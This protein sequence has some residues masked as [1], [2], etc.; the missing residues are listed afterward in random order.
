MEDFVKSRLN[1]QFNNGYYA[2]ILDKDNDS[3]QQKSI[4]NSRIMFRSASK[5]AT[6]EGIDIDCI[7]FD[8]YDRIGGEAE[9]SGKE[10]LA[11]SKYGYIRRWSTPTVPD[12]GIDKLYKESNQMAWLIRCDHCGYEQKM[13]Y[14]KNIELVD[15]S[16][17]DEIGK[18][19]LPG[20]YRFVCQRCNKPLDSSRWYNGHWEEMAPGKNRRHGY[21]ITQL[22]AVN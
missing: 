13:D 21:Q 12:W 18:I 4:R 2:S 17:I 11:S 20:T 15:E 5:A 6:M 16:G 7:S 9:L 19:V 3:L 1:P 14:V 8:E 22:D 10:S